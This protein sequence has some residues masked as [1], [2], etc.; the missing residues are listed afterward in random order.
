MNAHCSP[1]REVSFTFAH[2]ARSPPC[3][4]VCG[5]PNPTVHHGR[6]CAPV[7]P[8]EPLR[9]T[10]TRRT[11]GAWSLSASVSE[12]TGDAGTFGAQH[13]RWTP[14]IVEE[15]AGARAGAPVAPAFD[16]GPGLAASASL[17][18]AAAGHA[19]GS[20]RVGADLLFKLPIEVADGTYRATR[21]LTAL[22]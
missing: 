15:G 6:A 10:D 8:G 4:S 9:V 11:G 1:A 7:S 20:A 19:S 16:G 3:A 22:G 13:L 14:R 12:F 2:T 18:S 5:Y 17:A 21:T